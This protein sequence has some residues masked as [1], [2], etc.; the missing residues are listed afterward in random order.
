MDTD[1][2]KLLKKDTELYSSKIQ[3]AIR[4]EGYNSKTIEYLNLLLHNQKLLK[5]ISNE[6]LSPDSKIKNIT[7]VIIKEMKERD[8]H[9]TIKLT[10]D[11]FI[12]NRNSRTEF[13]D[14]V[15]LE[16]L[17][18][19]YGIKKDDNVEEVEYAEYFEEINISGVKSD[20]FKHPVIILKK[21]SDY[22]GLGKI[23]ELFKF[24]FTKKNKKRELS[25]LLRVL[26]NNKEIK[27]LWNYFKEN[28]KENYEVFENLKKG[29]IIVN[30]YYDVSEDA[31]AN[32][33][34]SKMF[35]IS[36]HPDS[37]KIYELDEYD[38][39]LQIILK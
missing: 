32:K 23:T 27:I 5:I 35:D 6:Y 25:P 1:T 9:I 16:L 37:K 12:R 31:I 22:I 20:Q 18:N 4:E 38:C 34:F 21:I 13:N 8:K 7:D 10:S 24:D 3:H 14:D 17:E 26:L 11:S 39:L 29:R 33:C 2:L 30:K 28:I 19:Q 36:G 15:Y